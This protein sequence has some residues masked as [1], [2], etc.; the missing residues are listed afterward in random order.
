MNRWTNL[1]ALA[2]VGLAMVAAVWAV[3]TLMFGAVS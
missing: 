1:A 3:A 2:F